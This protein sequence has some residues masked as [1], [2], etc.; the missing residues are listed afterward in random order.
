DLACAGHGLRSGRE[1][2]QDPR[3]IVSQR[4]SLYGHVDGLSPEREDPDKRGSLCTTR[5]GCKTNSSNCWHAN[6]VSK[7]EEAGPRCCTACLDRGAA[8]RVKRRVRQARW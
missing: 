2:P 6:V 4:E 7:Y 5:T 1:L 8:G 3:P